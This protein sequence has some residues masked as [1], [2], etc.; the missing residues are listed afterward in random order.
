MDSKALAQQALDQN[1]AATS[2]GG[3]SGFGDSGAQHG[4]TVFAPGKRRRINVIAICINVFFPFFMFATLFCTMSFRFHYKNPAACWLMAAAFTAVCGVLYS[5]AWRNKQRDRSP[6]WLTFTTSSCIFA[7]ITAVIF[8]NI[9]YVFNLLPYYEINSLNTY[10]SVNPATDF[11]QMLMD[12]GRV[13]FADGTALDMKK[14][15]SFKTTDLYCVVPIVTGK[16]KLSHYDFWAVGVNCCSS[17]SADF[18]CGQFNNP[19]ARSGIRLVWDSDRPYYRLAVQMAE[20][21]FNLN[22]PHPLFFTWIQDPM[23]EL[24]AYLDA[25]WRYFMLG[26]SCHFAFNLFCTGSAMIVFSKIGYM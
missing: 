8:G 7:V 16:E 17:V 25:G 9:N 11:G 15:T 26:V 24:N 21:Q 14:A 20:A 12:A 18:R 6:M 19:K 4:N 1:H 23:T 5:L 13:Y 10:P 3:V 22:A 2:Y